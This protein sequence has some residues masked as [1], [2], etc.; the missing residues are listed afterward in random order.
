MRKRI[1]LL[2]PEKKGIG[3]RIEDAVATHAGRLEH[4]RIARPLRGVT[5]TEILVQCVD[6]AA[7]EAILRALERLPSVAVVGVEE[8]AEPSPRPA[9]PSHAHDV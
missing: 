7:F 4:T 6:S 9:G 5:V 2:V 1:R 8:G 3:R